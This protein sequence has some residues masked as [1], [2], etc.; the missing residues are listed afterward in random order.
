VNASATLDHDRVRS[1]SASLDGRGLSIGVRDGKVLWARHEGSAD[2]REAA[3]LQQVC[4]AMIGYTI[5][6]AAEHSAIYA[7]EALARAGVVNRPAGIALPGTMAPELARAEALARLVYKESGERP[8]PED[9]NFEDRGLSAGWAAREKTAKAKEVRALL[10]EFLST[11]RL[12]PDAFTIVDIDKF[13]R[14]DVRFSESVPVGEKPKM[15]M[16]FERFLRDRTHERL[17]VFVTEMKDL[18]RIRRL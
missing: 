4:D 10:G 12:A 1:I 7:A 18:N 15:L 11:H 8:R 17:E 2:A 9:W 5:R 6:E 14:I 16:D 3:I 13:E